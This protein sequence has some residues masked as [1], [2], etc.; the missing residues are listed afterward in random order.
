MTSSTQI[1]RLDLHTARLRLIPLDTESLRLSL[2]SPEQ[3]EANLGLQITG[4]AP[5]GEVREAVQHMLEKVQRDEPDWLWYTNWQIVLRTENCI[6]GGFCF[7]GP[8]NPDGEVEI[9]YGIE[10]RY[11]RQGYVAEAL[12]EIARWAFTQPRV[13]A[14]VAET[15][16][17]N[18]ASQWV[19]K[20]V[21][22]VGRRE[23][24]SSLWWE[25]SPERAR[26]HKN[27][28]PPL[29]EGE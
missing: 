15:D 1:G 12:R 24:E 19:L 28:G 11:Q 8:A 14:I 29:K 9:G 20:R 2:E 10:P 23:S 6:I 26:I 5:E 7:K 16:R 3:M 25:L 21:G 22:F 27:V 13:R 17:S 18:T 4:H